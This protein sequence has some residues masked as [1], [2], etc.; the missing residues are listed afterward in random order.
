[1]RCVAVALIPH[2]KFGW[3]KTKLNQY[4]SSALAELWWIDNVWQ[5]YVCACV[6]VF[7][8][9]IYVVRSYGYEKRCNEKPNKQATK[10][11]IDVFERVA[12]RSVPQPDCNRLA[13]CDR[14][15]DMER[16]MKKERY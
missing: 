4:V 14:G 6:H 12:V 2:R 10:Q 5:H 16:Q 1:M 3:P 7:N 15:G 8:I 9:Y 11:C 13:V